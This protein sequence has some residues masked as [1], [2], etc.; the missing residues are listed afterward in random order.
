MTFFVTPTDGIRWMRQAWPMPATVVVMEDRPIDDPKVPARGDRRRR[1]LAQL[2]GML[3]TP[4]VDDTVRQLGLRL[5]VRTERVVERME[6]VTSALESVAQLERGLLERMAPIV[7][8][9]AELVRH[10]LDE[11]R[12]RRGLPPRRSPS[13]GSASDDVIDVDFDE[14]PG[15]PGGA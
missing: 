7:E 5:L 6:D 2:R 11:A 13:G 9:L 15:G 8:D 14:V 12:E 3:E 1:M 10:S 4:D